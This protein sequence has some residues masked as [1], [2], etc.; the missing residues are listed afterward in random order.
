MSEAEATG[1]GQGALQM[2]LPLEALLMKL[3]MASA[4]PPTARAYEEVRSAVMTAK[5]FHEAALLK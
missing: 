2:L 4:E 1:L 5:D 3:S